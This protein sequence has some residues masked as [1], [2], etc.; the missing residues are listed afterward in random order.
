MNEAHEM[1]LS[2][3]DVGCYAFAHAFQDTLHLRFNVIKGVQDPG[4]LKRVYLCTKVQTLM[5]N[6]NKKT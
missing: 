3:E 4:V 6:S 1:Q 2:G 5:L